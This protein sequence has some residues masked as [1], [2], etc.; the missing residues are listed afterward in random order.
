MQ[1]SKL[2]AAILTP[3]GEFSSREDMV[4]GSEYRNVLRSGKGV[5]LWRNGIWWGIQTDGFESFAPVQQQL[6]KY[7]PDIQLLQPTL[8]SSAPPE[9]LIKYREEGKGPEHLRNWVLV[10]AHSSR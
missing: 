1:V 8:S 4:S 2:S 3:P 7:F 9:I 6:S 10:C 5:Q